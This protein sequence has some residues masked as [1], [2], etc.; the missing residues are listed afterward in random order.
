MSD[1][2]EAVLASAARTRENFYGTGTIL[3]I[4]DE[5]IVRDVAKKSLEGCG[6]TVLVADSGR[7]A[8]DVFK[9]EPR[10]IC[11]VI[12][13]LSM[14]G[15]NGR[16]TLL[17]LM[18]IR[19]DVKVIVSSGYSEREAMRSFM[20]SEVSAFLQKPYTSSTLAETVKL[21]VA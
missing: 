4:D 3:V 20:G 16:E 12:L 1:R 8:I 6:Y 18:K 2:P 14:P 15:M 9:R 5:E 11:V 21:A 17:E 13:D 7:S 19:R 10:R